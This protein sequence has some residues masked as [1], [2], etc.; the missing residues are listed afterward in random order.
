LLINSIDGENLAERASHFNLAEA[1]SIAV[2]IA[3]ALAHAHSHGIV[4]RDVKPGNVMV[5]RD[6]RA[7]LVD[8]GLA[9]PEQGMGLT[10]TGEVLGTAD[11]PPP[12]S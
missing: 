7:M 10:V 4:H 5:R 11:T 1:R 2:D 6:N 3:E 12:R 8:F 9:R